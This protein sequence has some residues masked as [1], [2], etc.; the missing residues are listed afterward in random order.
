[1][2]KKPLFITPPNTLKMK[3]GDGGIPEYVVK[4]CQDFL[5]NNNVDFAPHGFRYLEQMS[6]MRRKIAEDKI[7]MDSAKTALANIVMQ[8]KSNGSMFHYQLISMVSDVILRFLDG[9]SSVN[10]DFLEIFDMYHR[11]VT[12]ILN[13]GL[14]GNGNSEGYALTQELHNACARYHAKHDGNA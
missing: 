9:T 7:D 6:D 12:I 4:Q 2:D 5:E 14:T 10:K 8:L 11:I 1:M 3:M 13:K